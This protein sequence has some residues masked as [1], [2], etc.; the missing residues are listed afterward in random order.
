[1]ACTRSTTILASSLATK[2]TSNAF[3]KGKFSNLCGEEGTEIR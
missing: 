2:G 1:M 3:R